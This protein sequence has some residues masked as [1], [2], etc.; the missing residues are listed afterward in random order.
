MRVPLY[1]GG[2]VFRLSVMMVWKVESF[3]SRIKK[4]FH[5]G[6]TE[7]EG[8]V[9]GEEHKSNYASAVAYS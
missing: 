5:E 8:E 1:L 7:S 6:I 4:Q 3:C 9:R 2:D